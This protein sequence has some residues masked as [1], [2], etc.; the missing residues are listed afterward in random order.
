MV[1]WNS[2]FFVSDIRITICVPIQVH[3]Y[4]A[5]ETSLD[6]SE[7][8]RC[9]QQRISYGNS[10]IL[11]KSHELCSKRTKQTFLIVLHHWQQVKW[12]FN[13]ILQLFSDD[14]W[15]DHGSLVTMIGWTMVPSKLLMIF[16]CFRLFLKLQDYGFY[17]K[18][19]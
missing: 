12:L 19:G 1:S 14:D 5:R 18:S 9:V 13:S 15:L 8:D 2:V 10:G 11:C 6:R 3:L 4:C 7:S 16:T 17:V